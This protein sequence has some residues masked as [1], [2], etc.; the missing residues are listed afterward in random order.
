MPRDWGK[1]RRLLERAPSAAQ[2]GIQARVLACRDLYQRRYVRKHRRLDAGR[3]YEVAESIP[4]S[5][6]QEI[7]SRPAD[8]SERLGGSHAGSNSLTSTYRRSSKQ[9]APTGSPRRP[10]SWSTARREG[11][12][13]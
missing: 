2:R 10:R 9:G 5:T 13:A 8:P 11:G 3:H 6:R 4:L 12:G 7:T 1:V